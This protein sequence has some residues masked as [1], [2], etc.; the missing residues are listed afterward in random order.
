MENTN[1]IKKDEEVIRRSKSEITVKLLEYL[2]PYK[3]KSFIVILLMIFVMISS[4]VNPLLLKIAIDKYVVNKDVTG[5]I[6]IGIILIVLNLLAWGLSKIRW[7]MITSITNN[8]LVN[9]RHELY[10]HIQYL[11]FDFFD[12]RPV[13]KILSRVVSDV[14]SLKNLFSQSIQSLIPQ[15]LNLLCVAIIMFFLNYKL[16]L[17]SVAL[18]PVLGIAMFCIEI[19]SRRRWEIYRNKRSNLNGFTHEDFSGI[20]IVQ[21]FAKEKG[22]ENN[23]KSM[24]KEL[25]NSFVRAV[26]LNDFFWPLVELSWGAG[27]LIVFAV[28]YKLVI[29]NEIQIGTLIA[30]SMYVGMFWRPIMNL[31]SFYNTLIT[32]FSAADRIFDILDMKPVI[33]NE[34]NAKKIG[35]IQGVVEFKDVNFSYDE[36]AKVLK[37]INFKVNKGEKIAL[38]GATGAGKTTIVSLLSRFYDPTSGEVLVDGKNIKNVDLESLRSQMGI[39]LQDTFLFSTTIMENI[40]YGRLDATDE[41]V[42][43]AAK[44]VNAHEFIIKLEDG[45]NTEVNERGTR[46]SLGQRQLV[47]FARALLANPRILILDEATSNIDTETEKLVQEGIEKLLHGRTSFVVAHRLSTIRDCDKIM[48]IND[49]RIEEVGNH[50]ELLNNKGSYYDLYMTQYKFLNEGA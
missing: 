6:L 13:G 28:G 42:I 9:I 27:T 39:M 48:V 32:N 11:S 26:M 43:N 16:A 15:L 20:K 14:N 40:R 36:N 17:A 24:V 31:S 10:S 12:G 1:L 22:T 37:D 18:L 35:K 44:A 45:Y 5:L 49:G 41:E 25:S 8:I 50:N 19:Y 38:V 46:L 29:N 33:K 3:F 23:F 47:S 30:F 21:G 4:I 34:E 7:N 2:K